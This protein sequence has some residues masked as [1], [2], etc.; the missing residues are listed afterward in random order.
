MPDEMT[1]EE[2]KKRLEERRQKRRKRL[3]RALSA[4]IAGII[5]AIGLILSILLLVIP[6][7]KE[8]QLEKRPLATIPQFT[9]S[10]FTSGE[11]THGITTAYD[12]TIPFRD[13]LKNL[14]N[15]MKN[16][17]GIRTENTVEIIGNVAKVEDPAASQVEDT[18]AADTAQT[19][20]TAPAGENGTAADA[21]DAGVQTDAAAA[22]GQ[23]GTADEAGAAP[24]ADTG[25][26]AA[27]KKDY[28][29]EAA[30]GEFTGGF[31]IINQDGHW[32][33][34]PLFAGGDGSDY[35]SF[36]N[37]LRA[38]IDP[39]I[40]VFAMPIPLASA[41]YLPENFSDYSVDQ[42][43]TF[44]GIFRMLD[45]GVTPINLIDVLG[46]HETEDIFLR[47]DHHWTALGAY[48]GCEALAAAA[49]VPFI[50]LA[51]YHEIQRPGYVGSMY[52]YTQSANL[53]NDPEVF[54]I[55]IPATPYVTAYHNPDYTYA[56]QDDLFIR[57][58]TANSYLAFH[59][60]DAMIIHTITGTK[61]GRKLLILKDSYGDPMSGLLTGSFEE[62]FSVDL[63]YCTVN[64]LEL[65]YDQGIT[66][67]AAAM[68]IDTVAFPT[69]DLDGL[70]TQSAGYGV[71]HDEP[72]DMV[73]P[74]GPGS[75]YYADAVDGKDPLLVE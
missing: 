51:D 69:G 1:R 72:E 53:L 16:L 24:A 2:R 4:Q 30:E 62:I 32:R 75:P 22:D 63:R 3:E 38:Q 34:L 15:S 21:A 29:K 55:Y 61:N 43:A 59:A 39:S 35:A 58:D 18:A 5:L 47:T 67:I 40:N 64:L 48:Y 71:P 44:E 57:T 17:F 49:G 60:G 73:V 74:A 6:R 8:S 46:A 27:E 10:G 42:R 37:S 25:T 20:A 68:D 41:Y 19:E 36:L 65:I 31:L 7:P 11:F 28:E 12:D 50:P 70:L 33:G 66:D 26:T 9:V 13:S 45:D 52:G 23:T 56:Y 14:N 54:S